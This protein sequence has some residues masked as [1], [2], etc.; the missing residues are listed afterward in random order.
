MTGDT[1]GPARPDHSPCWGGGGGHPRPLS[2]SVLGGPADTAPQPP[3]C[4]AL[5]PGLGVCGHAPLR[6]SLPAPDHRG[7]AGPEVGGAPEQGGLPPAPPAALQSPLLRLPPLVVPSATVLGSP[8]VLPRWAVVPGPGCSWAPPPWP[9][10]PGAARSWPCGGSSLPSPTVSA[11]PARATPCPPSSATAGV[12][13][14]PLFCLDPAFT[15]FEVGSGG[16]PL[17]GF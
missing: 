3:S 12:T 5:H 4:S 10:A 9:P 15:A 2:A 14:P 8:G 7:S 17:K 11:P 6:R 1:Q 16:K 13:Q